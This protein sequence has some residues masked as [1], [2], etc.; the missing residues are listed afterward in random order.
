MPDEAHEDEATKIT[1]FKIIRPGEDTVDLDDEVQFADFRPRVVP[2]DTPDEEPV[3]MA[4]KAVSA[5]APAPS[6]ESTQTTVQKAS[7]EL[8]QQLADSDAGGSSVSE[9][10]K[11]DSSS[12]QKSGPSEPPA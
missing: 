4:P 5:P 9:S 1:P 8:A 11:R 3:E 12:V 10:G 7:E 2:S 6:P